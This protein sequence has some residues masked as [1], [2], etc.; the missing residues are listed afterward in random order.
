M[1]RIPRLTDEAEKVAEKLGY[2]ISPYEWGEMMKTAAKIA[3][4][5]TGPAAT[6]MTY[7]KALIILDIVSGSIRKVLGENSE[8]R[9]NHET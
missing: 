1:E 6:T 4:V 5:L 8:G 2:F 3:G 9:G 7:R